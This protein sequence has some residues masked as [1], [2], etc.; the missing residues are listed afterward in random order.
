[1][2]AFGRQSLRQFIHRGSPSAYRYRIVCILRGRASHQLI[3]AW[4]AVQEGTRLASVVGLDPVTF[5]LA[6]DQG[7]VGVFPSASSRGLDTG[8]VDFLHR[9]HRF[10]G[11]LGFSATRRKRI[12]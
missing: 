5:R 8:N 11:A 3:P 7:R 12:G 6:R 1:M 2:R 10:E 9:H 4:S